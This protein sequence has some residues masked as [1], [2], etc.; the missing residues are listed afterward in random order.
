MKKGSL[1]IVSTGIPQISAAKDPSVSSPGIATQESK[2]G[3]AFG[4]VWMF[5]LL[6]YLR[7][8]ELFPE[9][10]GTLSIIK[11][12]AI[13]AVLAYAGGKLS[14]GEPLSTGLIEVKMM[15]LLA[16]LCLLLMP[17]AAA[18]HE[19]WDVFNDTFSKVVLIFILMVNLLDTRKRLLSLINI[20]LVG[21]VWIA[22][23]ALKSYME[24][25]DLLL[26]KGV[27]GRIAFAG[28]GMFGNPNDLADALDLL[29]PLA[30]ALGLCRKGIL[31]WLYFAAAALFVVTVQITFSRGGFLGLVTLG[32][33]MMWKLGRGRRV[34]M[35]FVGAIVLGA[36][37]MA[38]PGGFA[39]RVSTIFDSS[40]DQTG[41]SYQRRQ[42]LE[43]ALLV[44]R[45][46]PFGVGMGNY[47]MYSVNEEKAHNGYLEISAELGLL[48][49]L[50]YLIINF[51]PLFRLRR[52]E[53]ELGISPQ[54]QDKEDYYLCVA[55]QAILVS[56]VVCSFFASIEYLW[57]LYYPAAYSIA[58]TQIFEK[59]RAGIGSNV[60]LVPIQSS[61]QAPVP[62][63]SGGVLWATR[64]RGDGV[65]WRQAQKSPT[66]IIKERGRLWKR[67]KV[68]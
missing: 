50:A 68:T 15:V 38:S 58:L 21:G 41:S 3:V 19:S 62:K 43:R 6:I 44:V 20:V 10:F 67:A 28:G 45:S 29:I 27:P 42:L 40:K 61:I 56:Y 47:H 51:K 34:K 37:V 12:V 66:K 17:F 18:P 60:A 22:A 32:G 31:R 25:R 5:T 59:E 7:P 26:A 54:G 65:L 16:A 55:L 14:N 64:R 11:F 13:T 33:Y 2:Y 30:V 48:G 35:I 4:A 1:A 57:Y 63:A 8:N 24:G 53:K 52:M 49:L 39:N 46:R 9:I 23:G 36:T